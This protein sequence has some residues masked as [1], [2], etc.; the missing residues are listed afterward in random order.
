MIDTQECPVYSLI[1]CCS[2]A[3]LSVLEAVVQISQ[4][5]GSIIGSS[6]LMLGV[7]APFY[8][9]FPVALLSIPLTLY[10]PHGATSDDSIEPPLS[11]QESPVHCGIDVHSEEQHLLRSHST[12]SGLKY[13]RVGGAE[14]SELEFPVAAYGLEISRLQTVRD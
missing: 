13:V 8:F 12:Y 14:T 5:I 2:T 1:R 7:Y 6:L 10:L 3:I 9:I 11:R 4:L